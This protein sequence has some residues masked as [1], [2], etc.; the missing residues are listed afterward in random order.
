MFERDGL[1][2]SAARVRHPPISHAHAY[3]FDTPDRSI[4]FSGD[5]T[6][7]PELI[8]LAKGTDVVVHGVMHLGWPRPLAVARPQCAE[9]AQASDRQPHDDRAVTAETG[10]RTLA[11]SHLVPGDDPT[12]DVMWIEDVRKNFSG[13]IVVG[14]DL[15]MI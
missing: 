11:L 6:Y 4:V 1:K 9:P 15:M 13:E 7:S 3:R 2:V 10:A 14:R 12:T 5:T 8:A